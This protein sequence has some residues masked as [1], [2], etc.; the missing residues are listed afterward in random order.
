MSV[1]DTIRPTRDALRVGRR[2]DERKLR[3][4]LDPVAARL[5]VAYTSLSELAGCLDEPDGSLRPLE[6]HELIRAQTRLVAQNA[7]TLMRTYT[8][9]TKAR[10]IDAHVALEATMSLELFSS[11]LAAVEMVAAAMVML[12]VTEGEDRALL[13]SAVDEGLSVYDAYSQMLESV[14]AA[15]GPNLLAVHK[16]WKDDPQG[17]RAE[18]QLMAAEVRNLWDRLQTEATSAEQHESP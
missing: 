3:A 16:Y 4:S 13:R 1:L 8:G 17:A 11:Q 12:T 2:S 9:A 14:R 10:S 7:E 5:A 18:L 15:T 6:V